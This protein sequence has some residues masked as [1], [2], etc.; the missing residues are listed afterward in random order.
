MDDLL[1]D[2]EAVLAATNV[3]RALFYGHTEGGL[4]AL[5]VALKRPDLVERLLLVDP[6]ANHRWAERSS[7][8]AAMP[9][10]RRFCACMTRRCATRC[11]RTRG[12]R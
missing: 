8:G 5:G 12:K 11:R 7:E 9:R 10:P 4:L 3:E 6:M 1:L 2:V